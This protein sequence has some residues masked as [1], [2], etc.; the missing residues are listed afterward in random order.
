MTRLLAA[1]GIAA[2]VSIAGPS[3]AASASS[4][5]PQPLPPRCAQGV[6]CPKGATA[7]PKNDH[8]AQVAANHV[9]CKIIHRGTRHQRRICRR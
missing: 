4:L 3:L 7:G 1:L 9:H 2:A 6:N 8:A 5:N